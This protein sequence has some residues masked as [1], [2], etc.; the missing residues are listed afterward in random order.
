MTISPRPDAPDEQWLSEAGRKGWVVL[1]KDHRIRYRTLE[2]AAL[3]NA[4][5][6]AFVLTAGDLKGDEMAAIFVKALPAM[7][8]FLSRHSRPFIATVSRSSSVS[9][10]LTPER[11]SLSGNR[12]TKDPL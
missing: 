10:L 8:R 7:K 12:V 5:V 4:G 11:K 6:G 1:T 3:I 9:L 2:R